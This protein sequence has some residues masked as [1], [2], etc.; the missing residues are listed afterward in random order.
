MA[1]GCCCP[2]RNLHARHG[3]LGAEM[4]ILSRKIDNEC[5]ASRVL[6]VEPVRDENDGGEKK[7]ELWDNVSQDLRY[8]CMMQGSLQS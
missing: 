5:T 7:K 1:S 2:S 6:V 8:R 4:A 3:I